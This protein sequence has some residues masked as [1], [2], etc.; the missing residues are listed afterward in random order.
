MMETNTLYS[1]NS[2]LNKE[3]VESILPSRDLILFLKEKKKTDLLF[4]DCTLGGSGHFK[5]LAKKL[6]E[7]PN[8][9]DFHF[10]MIGFDKDEAAIHNAR[11]ILSK[12]FAKESKRLECFFYNQDFRDIETV[13]RDDF[14]DA[15]FHGLLADLGLSSHQLDTQNRG[16][17]FQKPGPLD[18][19]MNQNN[20]GLTAKEI[21]ETYD[22]KKLAYIFK[23]YGE[24]PKAYSLARRIA[25]DRKRKNL[26]LNDT[27]C[28]A[29]YI[30]RI[31]RYKNSKKHPA[32]KVF[33]ALRIEV[34]KEL[35]SLERLLREI[36][37]RASN[38]S[39]VS[40]ISFHS[41]E[42]RMV[43]N[44]F[45]LW[46]QG[47][48]DD[49]ERLKESLSLIANTKQALGK[50]I[51][52]KGLTASLED[53]QENPRARSARLRAFYFHSCKERL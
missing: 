29:N 27:V 23:T 3:A 11:K 2:V 30:K 38:F 17:S 25:D 7:E 4:V 34:N 37:K 24:E 45:R 50:D 42:D 5:T 35:E 8:Y 48:L 31:S 16:F 41:L 36:P 21:L 46:S 10:K 13:L 6:L 18:M 33:Q 15:F 51:Y 26:P 32:T 19:R 43:K 52:K 39:K 14:N 44:T 22:E 1:H 20:Q 9:Q 40:F 47:F 49:N 28:F 12:T 53:I